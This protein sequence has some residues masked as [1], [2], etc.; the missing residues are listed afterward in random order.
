MSTEQNTTHANQ[1]VEEVINAGRR[2][3]PRRSLSPTMWIMLR[4][5]HP[6]F[7]PAWRDSNST[8]RCS[9]RRFPTCILH[10]GGHGRRRG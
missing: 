1:F 10:G 9:V 3:V 4:F 6:A 8:S 5:H 2:T 7:Q